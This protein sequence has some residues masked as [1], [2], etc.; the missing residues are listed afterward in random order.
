MRLKIVGMGEGIGDM[1]WRE[2]V[3]VPLVVAAAAAAAAVEMISSQ[4][5]MVVVGMQWPA[6]V[7]VTDRSSM[8]C[9]AAKADGKGPEM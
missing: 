4:S 5:A 2:G 3:G 1:S 7:F 6:R 8:S 9:S